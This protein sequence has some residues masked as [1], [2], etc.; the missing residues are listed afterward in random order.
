MARII[1]LEWDDVEA[2]IVVGNPRAGRV[3]VEEAFAVDLRTSAATTRDATS[4]VGEKIAAALSAR[5]ISPTTTLVAVGRPSIELKR[6][7]LP[8]APEEELPD[9]VRF[10][11]LREFTT[12]DEDWPLDFVV[13]TGEGVV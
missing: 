5:H 12:L 8:P 7:S 6:L 13:L 4:V 2:R 11:A 9:L 3:V 10:Q 1:A